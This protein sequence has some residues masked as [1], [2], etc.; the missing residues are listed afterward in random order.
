MS[1]RI[2]STPGAPGT[3]RYAGGGFAFSQAVVARDLVFVSGQS[4]FDPSDGSVVGATIQEQA[5]QCLRNIEAILLAAG[6]SMDRIVNV[7][8]FLRDPADFAGMNEEWARWFPVD[9]PA[10]QG[11]RHWQNLESLRIAFAVVAVAS[12]SNGR[13]RKESFV[14]KR[15]IN[16]AN[17]AGT[18]GH[19]TGAFPY[20]QAVVAGGLVFVS[21][22]G[23][24]DPTDG[25]VVG[26]TIQEQTR[27]C[28]RNVEAILAAAGSSM[29]KVASATFILRDPADFP[30]M[31]EE[32]ARWFPVDPPARQG[33]R[34]PLD[35]E[36]LRI[37]IAVIAEA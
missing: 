27:Q 4:P 1:R 8:F 21:G 2:I 15:I 19:A 24:F 20:S 37:S 23:P 28:L 5:R 33:A 16:T 11:A 35:I 12:T 7:S 10:R 34:H 36:G 25:S 30:G 26:S 6:S 31:N 18:A 9:P 3:A 32:W 14:A 22:Q 17:A 13:R 29:N